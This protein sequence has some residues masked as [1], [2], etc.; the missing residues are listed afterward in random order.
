MT[1]DNQKPDVARH[2][3]QDQGLEMLA[4]RLR[5]HAQLHEIVSRCDPE[6][7]VFAEDLETAA[8]QLERLLA[9]TIKHC[10]RSHHDWEEVINIAEGKG[11][12]HASYGSF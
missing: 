3:N 7:V 4:I 11:K 12:E 1:I 2:T 8:T 5:E 10:P 9:L 6:Q